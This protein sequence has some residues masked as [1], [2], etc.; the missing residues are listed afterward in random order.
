LKRLRPKLT[1]A[2]V[3]STICLF[4]ALAG[5]T[6]AVAA[7]QTKTI[8]KIVRGMAPS[9]SVAHAG[10]ADTATNAGDASKLGGSAAAAFQARINGTCPAGGAAQ[11]VGQDGSLACGGTNPLDGSVT[12]A[13]FGTIPAAKIS[14]TDS[15]AGMSGWLNG[16]TC[17]TANV[18]NNTAEVAC[19]TAVNFDH[20]G[21]TSDEDPTSGH[22]FSHLM[23]PVDGTYLAIGEATWDA[24]AAGDRK[25]QIVRFNSGGTQI[26][27]TVIPTDERQ[28]V[29]ESG[30][31]TSQQATGL[32]HLNAGDYLQLRISQDSGGSLA[33]EGMS[34]AASWIGP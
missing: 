4:L 27:L 33:L 5:G 19:D 26:A 3:V 17:T 18:P 31:F 23:A 9:L 14:A 29:S 28:P 10:S 2:N 11:S 21:L 13:K 16:T 8:K 15:Q 30:H 12:P 32:I 24:N 1:Y 25:I 22:A 20:G 7:S 6:Y 34:F